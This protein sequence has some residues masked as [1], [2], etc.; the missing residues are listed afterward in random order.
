MA[1][2]P[3]PAT[4]S[5]DPR[6]PPNA[7]N[8]VRAARL[9]DAA[10]FA[11]VQHRAWRSASE[12]LGLPS[13]PELDQVERAWERAITAPPSPRHRSWVAIESG[14]DIEGGPG[15]AIVGVAAVA[16]ASDPDLDPERSVELLVLAVDPVARGRGHGSRLLS[17]AMQTASGDG[18]V[19]AVAWIPVADDALRGFLEESGWVA[20]GAFRTLSDGANVD[21]A[22]DTDD[23]GTG[24]LRQVRVATSLLPEDP[25][26]SDDGDDGDDNDNAQSDEAGSA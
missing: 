19:E 4:N 2:V 3:A 21:D 5:P 14:A 25:G 24:D 13:P 26:P 8:T 11:R 12:T 18:E 9:I 6:N 15:D 20:D 1:D 16:P 7:S 10:A 22:D 17:A 23:E